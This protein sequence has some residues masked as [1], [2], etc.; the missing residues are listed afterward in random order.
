MGMIRTFRLLILT[1]TLAF[2]AA[3]LAAEQVD[4]LLV[5]AADVSRSIDSEKFQLQRDGYAAAITDPRVLEAIKSGRTRRIGLSLVEWS[6]LSSQRVVI[7]WTAI[8]DAESAKSFAD[9]LLE[10][11]RSFADRTSISSAIEFAMGHL[12]RAPFESARHTIDVS[13]DGTNNSGGEVTQARDAAVAQGVTINGLV[14]LSETPLAWNPDHTN[15]AG[16]LENYYRNN[17][18]GGPGAFVMAAEGFNSF[19]R[20]IVKKMIAEV[21]QADQ[22]K[23]RTLAR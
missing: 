9:R 4:L 3:S 18:I 22:V 23:R 6:G 13:G 7:D 15:P 11:P 14:I 17:V 12:A 8:S 21:A 1:V 5:L 19:G 10:A 20:A 16:G 2:P